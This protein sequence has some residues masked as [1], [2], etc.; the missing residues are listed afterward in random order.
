MTIDANGWARKGLAL[1]GGIIAAFIPQQAIAG[2]PQFWAS[3]TVTVKLADKWNL[4][5]DFTARFSEKRNGLYELEANTLLGYQ[6]NK[7]VSVWGGYDHDPQ[8]FGGHFTVM[9]HRAIEHLVLSNF[10]SL[11]GGKF[12]SRIRL[13]QRWRT[14][15]DGTGWRVRPYVR[16]TV[17]IIPAAKTSL[18]LS[19]EPFIDLNTTSF[20]TVHGL[21]R[22]RSFVGF[23]TPMA[24]NLSADI[25]YLNQHLFIPNRKDESDN[26]AFISV[27]L[28][29]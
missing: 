29:L 21:E 13:E 8:Y 4:S 17:P 3:G 20:Q 22:V 15:K 26:V 9:E 10:A 28:K 1:I 2:D 24:K 11:A 6:I 12:S 23:T 7:V 25:G 27:G 18:T 14:G 19:V 5:Q 16:Y